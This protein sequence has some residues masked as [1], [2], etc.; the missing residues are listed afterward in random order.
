MRNKFLSVA[1]FFGIIFI[2]LSSLP[3]GAQVAG[4]QAFI[5]WKAKSY[6][7]PSFGGKILPG[8]TSPVL[9]D[10]QVLDKGRPADL[11]SMT[12]YWYLND[13]LINRGIG[14][15]SVTFRAPQTL[16]AGSLS[17][18]VQ[19]PDYPG[20]IVKSINIPV[21]QPS[22][23]LESLYPSGAFNSRSASVRALP[24]FFT[25][26]DLSFLS[27]SWSVNGSAVQAAENPQSLRVNI[28]QDA[29]PGSVL[30]IKV[31]VSNPTGYF[32]GASDE[33]NLTFS[34]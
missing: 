2:L 11:S 32:E 10:V 31:T 26:P 25:V 16:S 13:R 22:V 29:V 3:A 6:A 4:P 30:N 24:Y 15:Q 1:F 14:L 20:G 34:L 5:T 33:K 8:S 9:A 27:F 21:V 17:L 23:I 7:P 28:N 12:I 18:R 19:I